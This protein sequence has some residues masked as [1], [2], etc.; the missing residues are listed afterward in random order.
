[1][2]ITKRQLRRI[3]REQLGGGMTIF[4]VDPYYGWNEGGTINGRPAVDPNSAAAWI[5]ADAASTGGG[6]PDRAYR[7]GL[8]ALGVTHVVV[9]E[10]E[11]DYQASVLGFK[12]LEDLGPEHAQQ[13]GFESVDGKFV[14]PLDDW[15][16]RVI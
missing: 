1:M 13:M 16:T 8:R 14:M 12:S 10:D 4:E 9:G 3:I 5:E 6:L 11:L 7:E 2:K 15:P